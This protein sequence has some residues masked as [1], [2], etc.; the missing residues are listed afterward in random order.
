MA[1]AGEQLEHTGHLCKHFLALTCCIRWMRL[2]G[3][4]RIGTQKSIVAAGASASSACLLLPSSCQV[5]RI[6]I[7]VW[8]AA[9]ACS[10]KTLRPH[11]LSTAKIG[12]L[13]A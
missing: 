10:E 7:T 1:I 8:C 6:I 3:G 12:A 4:M 5:N 11:W 9:A 2:S 13:L